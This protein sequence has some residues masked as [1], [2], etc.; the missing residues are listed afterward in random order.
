MNDKV[1]TLKMPEFTPYEDDEDQPTFEAALMAYYYSQLD[2]HAF[3][4]QSRYYRFRMLRAA[5]ADMLAG[6]LR[7]MAEAYALMTRDDSSSEGEEASERAKAAIKARLLVCTDED[8][9]VALFESLVYTNGDLQNDKERFA[10]CAPLV[11]R[12]EVTVTDLLQLNKL[13]LKPGLRQK[14]RPLEGGAA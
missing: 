11:Q 5:P 13:L 3:S 10:D 8:E 2:G 6:P 7:P 1:L 4:D 9:A 14:K 12:A